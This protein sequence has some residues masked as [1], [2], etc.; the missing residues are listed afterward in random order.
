MNLINNLSEYFNLRYIS[1]VSSNY[2]ADWPEISNNIT[3]GLCDRN[4]GVKL[5]SII[6]YFNEVPLS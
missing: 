4:K 1:S 5:E 2:W 6:T 3:H